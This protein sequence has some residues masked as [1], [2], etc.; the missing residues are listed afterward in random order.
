MSSMF[1]N[2][3]SLVYLDLS[4]FDTRNVFYM[5]YMISNCALLTSIDV[6]NFNT[7]NVQTI[8]GLFLIVNY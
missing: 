8:S 5:D 2:C 4:N 1:E 7:Q 6:S 3:S